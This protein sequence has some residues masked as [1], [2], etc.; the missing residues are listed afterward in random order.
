ML[1][2]DLEPFLA[3]E[4]EI[5]RQWLLRRIWILFLLLRFVRLHCLFVLPPRILHIYLLTSCIAFQPKDSTSATDEFTHLVSLFV[6]LLDSWIYCGP[7][8][9][10]L[11]C[12]FCNWIVWKLRLYFESLLLRKQEVGREWLLRCIQ[13]FHG[14]L[15]GFLPLLHLKRKKQ[16]RL[17][18]PPIV[19]SFTWGH[20]RVLTLKKSP[21]KNT[22]LYYSTYLL[23][24][25]I[26]TH[27][28][29]RPLLHHTRVASRLH[30]CAVVQHSAL[31]VD[32]CIH[33]L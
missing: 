8:S 20:T 6:A 3:T 12:Y 9:A 16:S 10:E 15:V 31:I 27:F 19:D 21:P 1:I 14:L 32:I 5:G 24:R 29:D 28:H 22:I 33:H 2:L 7:S 26:L 25:P 23:A 18:C 17:L 4:D 30:I 11:L 13:V